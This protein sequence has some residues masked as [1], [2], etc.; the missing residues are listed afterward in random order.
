[1]PKFEFS[2]NDLIERLEI[3]GFQ[4]FDY[5]E[6]GFLQPY[7]STTGNMI[8]DL[9]TDHGKKIMESFKRTSPLTVEKLERKQ[10]AK[11]IKNYG[12]VSSGRIAKQQAQ[13]LY[14]CHIVQLNDCIQKSFTLSRDNKEAVKQIREAKGWLFKTSDV[15]QFEQSHGLC[16]SNKPK[17][18]KPFPCEAG[19]KWD[20]VKITLIAN[21]DT[22]KIETPQGKGRYT[23]HELGMAHM[24][25]GEPKK[26]W[27]TLVLFAI[28]QGIFPQKN[29]GYHES[30]IKE[31]PEKAKRLNIHLKELFGIEESIFKHHYKKHR[32]YET[33][34][35]F[36]DQTIS[37][38][39][40]PRQDKS[41]LDSE[42]E[43]INKQ[44]GIYE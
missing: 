32:R 38:E 28:N 11:Q 17:E 25:S 3:R 36:S 12:Y 4:L 41:L 34:I 16:K 2:G 18:V 6:K 39:P 22:V 10:R 26:V 30:V 42:V 27:H 20:D 24:V 33:K 40:E 43:E 9:N 19:T 31:L 44:F 1:M 7:D 29:Y 13:I 8:I 5:L 14:N 23:Y 37:E 15:L 21:N 35:K